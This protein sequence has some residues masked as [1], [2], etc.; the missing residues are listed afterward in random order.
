MKIT[1][2]EPQKKNLKRFNVFLD[3]EFAFGADEDL[4]VD[5]RLVVG[6][7]VN[8]EDLEQLLS[9]AEVG[10][11][12]E[13]MY[14]LFNVRQRSEREVRDYLKNLSFKR[15]LKGE[16]Q[17][18]EMAID[19]VIEKLKRKNMV[20]DSEFAKSWANARRRSKNKG[21]NAIKAELFQKGI[22]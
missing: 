18:S 3:G 9:E 2:V 21:K 4:I 12:M 5:R 19:S 14:R 20:N 10:K 6:K 11:M 8:K 16:D 17:I 1:Q 15:K 22:D 7:E 13:R